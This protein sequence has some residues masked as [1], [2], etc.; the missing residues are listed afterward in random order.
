MGMSSVLVA[1][2]AAWENIKVI[3]SSR[4]DVRRI[5]GQADAGSI[6]EIYS[7]K[8]GTIDVD[9]SYGKCTDKLN[10]GWDIPEDVVVA[11]RFI[12]LTNIKF[13]TLKLKHRNFKTIRES[14]DVPDLVTYINREEGVRYVVDKP[15]DLLETIGFF[16][17]TRYDRLRCN[18]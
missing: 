15:T 1:Q 14:P 4:A 13:S 17:S 9:Y 2:M 3:A 11:Y 6:S 12:P 7:V 8:D 18:L 5:L 16:P 10:S